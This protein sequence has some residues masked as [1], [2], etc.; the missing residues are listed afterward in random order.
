[1][2]R[3]RPPPHRTGQADFR[4]DVYKRQDADTTLRLHRYLRKALAERGI[5]DAFKTDTMP[6]MRL[7]GDTE[8]DGL[9]ID[10][11]AVKR[12]RSALE[13]G[14]AT[15]RRAIDAQGGKGADLELSL[16]HI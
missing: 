11:R 8:V 3:S 16:I 12:Q 10:V 7:L 1:M 6:L 14:T 15:L 9:G 4:Q 5:E 13:G 2:L